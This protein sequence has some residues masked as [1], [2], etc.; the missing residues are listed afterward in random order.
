MFVNHPSHGTSIRNWKKGRLN[1]I[2]TVAIGIPIGL[3]LVLLVVQT[4][5]AERIEVVD[6]YTIDDSGEVQSTRL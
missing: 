2:P 1:E 4:P 3:V 6:L 5:A